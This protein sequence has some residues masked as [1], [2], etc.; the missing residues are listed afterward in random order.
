MSGLYW[1]LE[2]AIFNDSEYRYFAYGMHSQMDTPPTYSY[3]CTTAVFVKYNST[4][5]FGLYDF[6]DKFFVTN[7]QVKTKQITNVEILILF[8]F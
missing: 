4:I 8:F 5:K 1:N 3:V 7:L 2:K 6:K